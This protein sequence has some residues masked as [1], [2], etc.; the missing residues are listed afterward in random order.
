MQNALPVT[1]VPVSTNP[2][3]KRKRRRNRKGMSTNRNQGNVSGEIRVKDTEKFTV[4]TNTL[5]YKTF[6]FANIA[7]M[8]SFTAMYG[9]YMIHSIT[10]KC[11][12]LV[13]TASTATIVYGVMVDGHSDKVTEA[14]LPNLKPSRQHHASRVSSV[15]LTHDIQL[16]KWM[17]SETHAFTL[18]WKAS[19]ASAVCFEV[20]YDISFASPRPI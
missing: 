6:P 10:I 4:T 1:Q 11:I 13:G 2:P 9:K 5:D 12:G 14:T 19:L 7:R 20:S 16:S 18:Y 17:D 3:R 8:N 15:K